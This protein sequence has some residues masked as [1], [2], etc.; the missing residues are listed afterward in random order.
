M[1]TLSCLLV[2]SKESDNEYQVYDCLCDYVTTTTEMA[3]EAFT[4]ISK[5]RCN[6]F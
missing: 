6:D 1:R 2:N 4:K 3:R 5:G